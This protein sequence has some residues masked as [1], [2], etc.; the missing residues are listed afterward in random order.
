MMFV[1]VFCLKEGSDIKFLYLPSFEV[2]V[3]LYVLF[4]SLPIRKGKENLKMAM[5]T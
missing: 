5:D 2:F 1:V 3:Y 4:L